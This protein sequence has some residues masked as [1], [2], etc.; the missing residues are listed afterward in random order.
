[1]S[2]YECRDELPQHKEDTMKAGKHFTLGA[3]FW[4]TLGQYFQEKA[5]ER[6]GYALCRGSQ[7]QWCN[8]ISL[9]A[10]AC[11]YN[12][13]VATLY[14]RVHVSGVIAMGSRPGLDPVLS[15]E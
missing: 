6:A 11:K 1:M 15:S 10:S 7:W 8:G 4:P 3:Y 9:R 5:L 12:I 14:R 2:F 13:P